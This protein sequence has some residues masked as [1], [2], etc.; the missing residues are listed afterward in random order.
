M[1]N[2]TTLKALCDELKVSPREARTRLRAAIKDTKNFPA[3]NKAYKPGSLW[4]WPTGSGAEAE[5]RKAVNI[6]PAKK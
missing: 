2:L 1:T 5:A 4:Q 3:L 6:E